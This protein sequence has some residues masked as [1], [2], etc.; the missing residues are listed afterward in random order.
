ML[1]YAFSEVTSQ[2]S[3]EFMSLLKGKTCFYIKAADPPLL[4]EIKKALDLAR[5][6]YAEKGW[7]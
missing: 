7:V 5:K 3:P 4:A 1:A 6:V 2:L